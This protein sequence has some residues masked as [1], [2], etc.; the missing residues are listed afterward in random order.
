MSD[1]PRE[2]EGP[3]G[4]P[5]SGRQPDRSAE[6]PGWAPREPELAGAPQPGPEGQAESAETAK[7]AKGR[8]QRRKRTGWRRIIPTWRMVLGTFLLVCLLLGGA[9]VAGYLIVDIPPANSAATAQTN[10][11]LYADGKQ[12]ARDGGVNRENIPLAQVPEHVRQAVLAAEDRDFY[13]ESA[14]DPKA[15]LRAA[16]NTVTGKGKQSGSTIT[17]QYVKNYYLSQDQT[18]SRKVKEFFIAIK[19][20]REVSKDDILEGYLNTSYFGRNAYGISAAA[21]AYYDKKPEDLTTAEGAYLATLLNSPSAYDV[22]AHPENKPRAVGRWNYVL[23]GMVKEKWLSPAERQAMKFPAPEAEAGLSS[24]LSGQ[25]GYLVN[26]VKDYLLANEIVTEDELKTGGYRITTTIDPDQQDAFVEAV[27]EQLMSKLDPK[28]RKIDGSVRVGGAAIDPA[29]GR[30]T[31]LYGGIDYVKQFTNNATRRDY[32]PGST[33]KPFVLTSAVENNSTTQDGRPITPNT[34]YDGTSGRPVQ[35]WN[36]ERFAPEN[37]D[38]VDYGN[39]TVRTAAEKS[40]NS[41]FAQ[42]AVDVGPEKVMNTAVDLGIPK[43]TPGLGPYPSISLGTP[44]ASVLDVTQAYATLANHG[45]HGT[46]AL[47]D[48]LEKNGEEITLPARDTRQAVSRAAADTT[49]S[50][51]QSVVDDGTG[52]A[53]LAAGRPAAGKTGTAE[54]DKA[55]WFAGYTPELATVVAVM[56]QDPETAIQTPLYGAVG[57]ARMNGGGYPARIWAQFT[58]TALEGEPVSEFDLEIPSGS[59]EPPPLPTVP[60]QDGGTEGQDEGRTQGGENGGA[61][62]GQDEGQTQGP[63]QGADQGQT[64]GADQGQ[65]EGQ[66]QGQT[67]GTDQGQSEGQVQGQTNGGADGGGDVGGQDGGGS[68]GG[69]NGGADA[70][71]T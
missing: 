66:D 35:G 51:L 68:G 3:E 62:Q 29:T 23:D 61:N 65:T 44:T 64:Q 13:S 2:Q 50:V 67:Q 32:Q 9:L 31:A 33:L 19:L 54:E 18:I 34:I 36:G 58:R 24:G 38:H 37:E 8:K 55:A 40:V 69:E 12:L 70:G 14:V 15:M 16:W 1:E 11:Y 5:D 21:H 17:Q 25:R 56:G 63:T 7:S 47:V 28:A 48:K 26:A 30:V 45:R 59:E 57:Q 20:G 46:Y 43:T 42:M 22:T 60:P 39:I 52:S 53:A 49:T 71:S 6:H 10:V 41:V 4:G 27:D